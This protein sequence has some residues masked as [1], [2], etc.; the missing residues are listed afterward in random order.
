MS[1]DSIELDAPQSSTKSRRGGLIITLAIFG[2]WLTATQ[3]PWL[4][5]QQEA[6][7]AAQSLLIADQ[8]LFLFN[9]KFELDQDLERSAEVIAREETIERIWAPSVLADHLESARIAAF[10]LAA[11]AHPAILS[12]VRVDL[13]RFGRVTIWGDK[14][15]LAIEGTVF[16]RVS[17]DQVSPMPTWMNHAAQFEIEML[18]NS[19]GEWQLLSVVSKSADG[20]QG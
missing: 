6:R 11:D 19:D 7:E 20:E 17:Q 16:S 4:P 1:L 5:A 14:A 12:D 8:S 3:I 2:A 13:S 15:T 18:R 10:Q 9:D